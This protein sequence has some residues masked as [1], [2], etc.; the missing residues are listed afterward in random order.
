MG[1]R[2]TRHPRMGAVEEPEVP[3]RERVWNER[4]TARNREKTGVYGLLWVNA[5]GISD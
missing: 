1:S 3:V 4:A 5:R 2:V